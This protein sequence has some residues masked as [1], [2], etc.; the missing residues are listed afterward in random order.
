METKKIYLVNNGN[1]LYGVFMLQHL[2]VAC[3]C[4]L[5]NFTRNMTRQEMVEVPGCLLE[6]SFF[7]A[8]LTTLTKNAIFSVI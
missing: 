5:R 4:C 3:S 8:F 2:L 6:K 7:F 1:W